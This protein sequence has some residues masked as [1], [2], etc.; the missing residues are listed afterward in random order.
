MSGGELFACGGVC[1]CPSDV[2][3]D[4]TSLPGGK[5]PPVERI[6][7]RNEQ[8]GWLF[9]E[10][11]KRW[12]RIRATGFGAVVSGLTDILHQTPSVFS[13]LFQSYPVALPPGLVGIDR[14]FRFVSNHS[15]VMTDARMRSSRPSRPTA[16]G[17]RLR[18]TRLLGLPTLLCDFRTTSLS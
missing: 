2:Y 3:N 17:V 15:P 14:I 18:H 16:A 4:L 9:V 5:A 11:T 8:K 10:L 7:S 12:R 1:N 6:P 13:F